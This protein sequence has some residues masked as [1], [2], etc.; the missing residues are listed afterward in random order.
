VER[1]LVEA[2]DGERALVLEPRL[3]EQLV[4]ARGVDGRV[5]L[6]VP[7]VGDVLH[8]LDPHARAAPPCGAAGR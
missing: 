2:G 4:L 8:E 1:L 5:V 3:R 7:D 6:Q